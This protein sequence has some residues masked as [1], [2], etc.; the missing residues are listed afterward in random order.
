LFC[1]IFVNIQCNFLC[2]LVYEE[3]LVTF[4]QGRKGRNMKKPSKKKKPL[5]EAHLPAK[6][7]NFIT[8]NNCSNPF[9][10]QP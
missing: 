6:R 10:S 2:I 4:R 3:N 1:F 9:P 8:V 7:K 5:L